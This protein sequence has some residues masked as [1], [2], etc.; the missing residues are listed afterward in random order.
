[1]VLSGFFF[2]KFIL[3]VNKFP[4]K[5]SFSFYAVSFMPIKILFNLIQAIDL[6]FNPN[7]LTKKL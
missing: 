1:M 4:H 6:G 3:G 7:F 5:F 2:L